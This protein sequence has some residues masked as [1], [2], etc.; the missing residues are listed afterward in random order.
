MLEKTLEEWLL[1][2]N[3]LQGEE[4]E[5]IAMGNLGIRKAIT[6]EQIIKNIWHP[7]F[8]AALVG[9]HDSHHSWRTPPMCWY[10][11]L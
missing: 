1:Y 11:L 7:L 9:C 4:M 5:E 6:I 8:V 2:F 3:N 10:W